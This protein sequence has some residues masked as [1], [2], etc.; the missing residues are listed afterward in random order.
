MFRE[1][2]VFLTS[3][4]FWLCPPLI[5][6]QDRELS[7]LVVLDVRATA[8]AFCPDGNMAVAVES[9]KT[10]AIFNV[11]SGRLTSSFGSSELPVSALAVSC[12]GKLLAA[13]GCTTTRPGDFELRLWNLQTHE[14][15]HSNYTKDHRGEGDAI[16]PIPFVAFSPDSNLLVSPA[17]NR[18]V[19]IWNIPESRIQKELEIHLT[20]ST[21]QFSPDGKLLALGTATSASHGT[22]SVFDLQA[23]R[24]LKSRASRFSGVLAVLIA[25]EG[26]ELLV[27]HESRICRQTIGEVDYGETSPLRFHATALSFSPDGDL[28]AVV[29]DGRLMIY[30]SYSGELVVNPQASA[31]TVTFS[32]DGTALATIGTAGKVTVWQ[33]R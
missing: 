25:D 15:V 24:W 10:L 19:H 33:L 7:E 9:D 28:V 18:S 23:D 22:A 3:V 17:R 27:G 11:T 31:R 12:D 5:R 1:F 2:L 32:S 13:A 4:G 21:V 14:L 26:E 6:A 29:V 20:P 30:K 8:V 16:D